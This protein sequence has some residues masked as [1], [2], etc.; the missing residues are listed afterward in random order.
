[1]KSGQRFAAVALLFLAGV[2]GVCEAAL[3]QTV[4]WSATLTAESDGDESEGYDPVAGYGS[5][6][7][8]TFTYKGKSF[9]VSS[10]YSSFGLTRMNF[11]GGGS[12]V[13]RDLFGR[14]ANP[15]PV[16]LNIG[17][18]SWM[19]SGSGANFG[20]GL[21]LIFSEVISAGNTYAVSITTAEPGPPQSLTA[22]EVT[23]TG[24]TLNWSGPSSIGGSAITGYKYR[25]KASGAASFG[26]WTAISNSASL[27]SHPV[28]GLES[29]TQ[30][31]FQI[32]ATNDSGDGLYSGE[33]TATT[34]R[35]TPTVILVLDRDRIS[36]DGGRSTVTA[37]LD[38]PSAAQITVTVSASA[39]LPATAD[40]FTL[41]TNKV[42]TIAAEQTTSTG[43]VTIAAVNNDDDD[44]NRRVTLSGVA[45]SSSTVTQPSSQPLTIVDDESASTKVTLTVS[46]TRVQEDATGA[47]QT[48]TVSAELDGDARTE[49]TQVAVSVSGGSAVAGTHYTAVPGFTFTIAAGQTSGAGTFTLAPID[50]NLNDPEVTVTV[51]GTTTSGLSVEP[52]SGLAVTIEDDDDPPAVTLVLDPDSIDEDGGESTVTATLDKPSIED[53]VITVSPSPV[54]PAIESDFTLSD[55]T[56]LTIR[57]GDTTSSGSVTITA[58]NNDVG[59]GDQRVTVSGEAASDGDLTPPADVTLTI[60]EDDA[61]ATTV[62]LTVD[63][64]TVAED[65]AG[66][67]RTVTVTAVL[68]GAREEATPVAVSVTGGTA[69]A[70]TDYA[71]VDGFTVTIAERMKSGS[72]T[73]TLAPVDDEVDEPGETVVLN[74][75]T[76]VTDLTVAPA[77][78]VTVTITDNDPRPEVTLVLTPAKIDEDDGESTV[79]ATLDRPSSAVTRIMVSAFPVPPAAANEFTLSSN[80]VLTIAAGQKASTG[81][82]TI[83]ANDNHVHQPLSR[84]LVVEGSAANSQGVKPPGNL[85]LTI[86]EDEVA[87]TKVTLSASPVSVS[88]GGGDQTVTLTATMDEGARVSGTPVRISVTGDTAVA[89]TDYSDVNDF[90]FRIL[91]GRTSGTGTFTLTPVD[92]ETDEPDETVTVTATTPDS[93]GL[94]VEPLSGL[95]VTITDDDADAEPLVLNLNVMA[96]DGTVNRAEKAAGFRISGD[97][98]SE[99]GVSV[100]VAVGAA[101]LP[102]TSADESGTATWSVDVPANAAYITGTSVAVEVNASKTGFTAPAAVERSLTVDLVAPTAPSYTAPASLQVGVAMTA[103]SPSG[104]SGIDEYSAVGLPSGLAIQATTGALS[105]TP[106]TADA[107]PAAATV[108]VSD[109]AGNTATVGITLPLVAKGDQPL[110]GFRYSTET[111]TFGATAPTLTAPSGAVTTLGYTASPNTVCTVHATTGALTIVAVGSCRITATAAGNANYNQATATF[112]VTVEAAGQLVLNL[113]VMAGD[114]TVNRAEKAAGFRIS[115]DTGSEA[116]VSVSVAVGAATLP[117]TSADESGTATW[118]VDVPANAAYIT[119]TSVAVEVNASKTGFTAPAAVERSLTVDLVAPTAPSYTAP[120]SLQ[121]GVAMTAISPSGGSGI[122]E[123]SAVGLPSGLAIQATTGALSGT[124][125]TADAAPAAATVTVSDGAGNTATVGITLPLVAKG[126]QPLSGFRYSAETVT[127]GATAPTLTAPS[128]AVTTLGYTASPNTVCTVHATTGALTIVAVGSCRITATAAGNANYN[129]ATATFTVTVEAA[130]QLV[131]NLNVMAGDGT[132]NRAE[133]AAGFR[134]SGDTGSEAGVSVSVAVGAA[135]LPATSADESGTATWSVDVPANAAY[136]TGTSVAVEVNA[137][138]TGFT[139]PAAVERSL[140]VDLVAPTAPS[141]TAPASLQVGVAMTAISPSGGSGIDEYSAVGLPSGLAIQATTGALSG[142]PD[143]ADAAPAAATVTVSDGAGNT[144]TVGITLPLVAKGDQPLSGFRYSA[145][146]VTFGATAPTLT[147][148]SGAVTTLGYTASPNTVCTVH[149]TTGALTI[150]AVGSCRIT[151]TAAGNANYNQATATFT[152]TVEAAGQ[153]VLNLNVMAGDGTVNRAEKAAGFRISGDT[154]SEAGVSVSVAVGA[155]TLPATSADESGTATWSVDVP[156]NAAYITGTSVAVE[157]NAS[158]TGFTAPAA[159]ERSLTVDLVAPTAPSYTAPASLQVGVAMTA[160]SPSGGSGIDEYSAVGLPSGLAI[161]ATTGALSGTPDTADAAPAAATVTV[162]DGAG[163]TATV[164]I[165]LPLVAKGDQPLSGFRYSA[166]TVTF[167]ATAPTL[168]APSGAVTTLGYTASPNTVCTVHATT[169]ALTIVAVGSCRI[170]ATAAGN[171]NYNQA[172]ATFTVTVEAAGQLVLNLNVMAGDGTVNRAEKAAGFRISG[173]TGSEAGVSVSVAVGAATLP[174]TSADESGTATWSVDVP[175]NAAYITGTSVAVE[176]NASKTGFTAPAAVERSL[177]VDLV[178]PTAPSYTAPASLQ[179]GVAMTAI[180]PSGGSGIDEYSAVGLPSGL[181]IQA[182]TGALSGTPD[183][184]DAAPAAATVT[185]S[186]GAG[187]TATVG[188]TLPLVAKGDQPLSGFRYSA[189][190]VTFGATAPTLTAPSGAVTT[191]GYTA[192]PNTVCTVHATTGALT[193]VAVGS[194]RITA[195]AAGNANYNQATATFTVTVEAAGQ[196]VLNLNVMAGDGTVN[197]A[198]KAAGFRISGDTG[199]EAGVSVSVAVGAATLPATSADES[200]TATWSVDVPA[201][202]AYITGTSV[203]VEVNASKTGFTAPAAVERSLTVDLVAP[204]APSYTAPASLQVGVAMTAISPSGGSGIDEYSAVGLPSGLAIQATTGALSG[205]PDTADA[206][207]AAATVTVSDGAGN[208]ATVGITLPL[209]AKGDQPLSGFRYSAETV[210]FG[211]TAPTLTAPSGAVTTLGYTA[212]PNTVCTVHATTGALTI[213]AVGSCRIT[214]TAAGNANY[215]QA[216]A[217]FT[218]TVEAAGQLVLNLNVMA[219]DGTVNRA[220]K[221]AGFRISGDTGSEAGVSVSVAVGAATLPATSADESGTATWSV[222]VP[223]NAAYITGTSVAVEVNASKTGFTAPAAV[224]RSLTVDLV[225]PTAPSYTAPASLQVGVAMTAISPS[226]GSGIDEYSAVGLPSG[227][228]IQATTGALSGTPDTADAAPAAA[229]VTVSDG[230]GNTATVG[231]TLPLVAK[232]DQPLSGFRYSAETVTFGAT[233]PTLTAPSGAVTTLGYTASPNTV[234]TV[235]ATTGALTIVAVGSCRITA[236]AAGNANYNQATATFTVT[237]EAAGQLVLN[238]NV[239]AGDGTVNRAEKAAGFRISGD[240]GSE[241]GVSVSVAVGAATLPATSADESGTATWSVDVPANAAYITG[242]SVAVEVNASKTGFTAPAA[243]ERSLTVDLVAPTAPSY[244]A[245]ASLQVGVAMTAISPSGGSGIDEYSAVGL[246][247]G[248]AIQATTGAL[249]GTPDTADAA[250]A[251][252]TVTVSDGAGNTA[253]VGI[254]LPLVAKGDQPLSGFR[255]SAETVTFG[256]TAPTLTAPSGAVTTLGYT[257]SPNTVCTVHATTGALTIVAVGSCR[258]TATAAGNANYNQATATF[259]VTVEAA[260]QLVLNLNVMAGDGTVNR[261]EKAA[262]FRISGDTGSEAGVSVSVAVGA[263]TLPA[264]SAD[265][266]GTATWSVDVPANAAYITGTSVAV[267]VNASKTGFTAPAAVERSLTV[268]LVAPTAP[269]YTAPA[270]LQVGVAMTAISPSGGSGIDEYSAV[271][272]PSGLAIQAT[273]G[274]LSGTPDTADAAPAAATVTVSDGAGNTATVGI[275]LPLVA[276]G[277]QPLSGFRYSAETV[278]FGA[279]APTLTAPSGAVTTLGY[280]ASP[281]TV[282]TVHATTG[283]LTIVAVGSCRITATAAGNA[284]YNQ[285]TATFTVTVE[286]AGQLVLNLN[287][288]AGDGTVNRAEKAAGFR[289]SGDTG[290]EAGVS[291]SVAVGAAT[292]PATSADESGTA[293]WSVDVPANAAYITGTSVA[294]EVNASKTGFTAP[295]AVERS[296]TVDLVAPTAPSY[297]AP[298]SLQVGVAMTAISPSGGSGIDEYSAVGLPSGLAIQA[299]TGALSGTPDTADA[300]PAAATVTVSDGAGNTATVGI[301]LPLVAK[302]DQPLSGFRYSAETVTFGATAPTLTAPSGAVTT[303]GY[304][305]SPNTVCTVHATTGALTIVAVGSCRITATAAG[306]ANYNQ[307]TATFTVTVE[308]AGQL[309]LNL[310]VMAGDGTVNRAEKAAGFRISGDTGS[311]AGVSVSVA[312]GAATLPATSADESGTATWSVDVPANAA[313]ITGTSVAVEVNASKTGF[314]A[315]AAVERSLTVDL[316]APTAPSYTAPASLQVGVAM[317]AISPSGGSGIDEYSAVGLPSGLAIQA[318]TGALSGT[319]DTADAAPAAATVTVSDGAGNTATVGITLPL[320]AKGD[321]PLSG[322]RYSAETVTF[323]ATAPTLTAPS[324]AVTTLGYTASPNTV[325]TVHATTGALTIVAVGS[326]RITATAAGNANYNQA[327]ATFTV[328]VESAGTLITLTV[329]DERIDEDMG[330]T[331][332]TVTGTL[333]N[334][335][336]DTDTAVTVAVGALSDA[337]AEGTDYATVNDVM[338]TISAGQSSGAATLSLRLTDDDVD[339]VDETLSLTGSTSVSGLTVTGTTITIADNDERGVVV[340]PTSL[341]VSEGHSSTYSV[342]LTSEPTGPVKVTPSVIGSSNVTLNASSFTFT[343]SNWDTVQTVTVLGIQDADAANETATIGHTLI[344]ADYGANSVTVDDVSVIVSDDETASTGIALTVSHEGIDED[345][346]ATTVTVTGTLNHAPRTSA[347]ALAVSVGAAGDTAVE[348]TDYGT[349]NDLRLTIRTGATT[350]TARFTLT[351][352]DDDVDEADEV[353]TVGGSTAVS[354]LT[355]SG[356]TITIA[357][358]DERAVVVTPTLL[359]VSEG[360]SLTYSVVLT[361]EPA[362]PVTVTPSVN[363]SAGVTLDVSSLKFT[364]SNWDSVQTVTVSAAQDTDEV[365]DTAT[366]EHTVSGADYGANSVTADDVAVTV[367]DDEPAS[368]GITLTVTPKQLDEDAGR[369]RVTVTGTLNHAP[370]TSSTTVTV[371]VGASSDAAAEGIDYAVVNDLTL[372]IDAGATTGTATFTLTP[373][374]DKVDEGDETLEVA[375]ASTAAGLT[376]TGTTVTIKENDESGLEI[377]TALLTVPEGG[378]STYMVALT[379]E[380]TDK[381]TVTMSV[382]GD[383][384]LTLNPASLSFTAQDWATAQIV[385]VSAAGDA[386]IADDHASILHA[387]AGGDYVSVTADDVSVTVIDDFMNNNVPVFPAELPSTL[388]VAE[389]AAADTA[390]GAP[391]PATDFDGHTLAYALEGLDADSFAI[392][393]ASA[394]LKALVALDHEIR[395]SYS[396]RV[397]ANDGHGG[398]AGIPV[399]VRVTDVT[400]QPGTPASPLVLASA[401]ST[402][403]LR[404]RWSAPDANGGPAITGYAVQYRVATTGAWTFHR[405][406]GTDTRATIT[407][408][409]A[410]TDYQARVRALNGEIPGE[411]SQPGSGNTGKAANEAPVFDSGLPAVLT[412]DENNPADIELGGPFTATDTDGDPLTYLLDGAGRN[413]FA[414][415]P[416]SGQIRTRAA[417]DHESKASYSV[418]VRADD[419]NGGTGSIALTVSVTDVDEQVGTPGAPLVLARRGSSISVEVNWT[420]PNTNGGPAIAGYAV[421]YREVDEVDLADDGAWIDHGHR[422]TGTRAVISS[423]NAATSYQARVRALNGETPGEWSEPGAGSTGTPANRPP[424][425]DDGLPA[426]VTVNENIV[427]NVDIGTPFAASDA[428]GDTLTFLMDGAGRRA[429]AI[430]PD[431][432]QLRT[433]AALDHEAKST[434]SLRVRVN[435]GKGGADAVRV[436]VRIIDLD[437]QA[438]PLSAPGVLASADSITS[439]DLYWK[440]PARTGGPAIVGY[441]VQYRAGTEGDW[442]DHAHEGAE[443]RAAVADLV[444]AT[445]YQARVRALNGEIPGEWSEPGAGSTGHAMNNAPIFAPGLPATLMVGENTAADSDIGAP[446]AATDS[447]GDT[448]TYLLDGADRRAFTIDPD[449]GQLRTSAALDHETKS[450]YVL[451][452]RVSDGA[453]GADTAAVTVNV[454]DRLEKAAQTSPPFVLSAVGA[455]MALDVRWTAPSANGG[456]AIVGYEMQYREGTDDPW[457]DHAHE[458]A[459]TRA[460]IAD[461]AATTGYQVRVRALNGETPGDWSAPGSGNTA[462]PE[463]SAPEFAGETATR[464]VPENSEAGEA[465]GAAVTAADADRDSLT[466]FLEG[467]DAHAFDIDAQTGQ[468]LTQAPLDYETQASYSVMVAANDGSGAADTIDVTIELMDMQEQQAALGPAAPTRVS[469]ARQ[470]SL[471]SGN[472]VQSQITL[473]WDAKGSDAISWFEFR[474]GR[475]PEASGGLAPPEFQCA[476]NRPFEPDGWRRIPDSG[477]EGANARSY[478]FDAQTLGCH[479]LLDTYELRAQARAVSVG[480]EGTSVTVS[481]ASTEARMRDEAPRVVGTWLDSAVASLPETGEDL[482]LVVAFTEPV[483]VVMANGSPTLEIGLGD[484]TR[485]A[486]FAAAARPPAFRDYGSGHIGSRLEFRYQV[487]EDDDLTAGIVVPANAISISSGARI[488][489]ATG[490]RGHAADLRNPRTTISEGSTVV[491]TSRQASLTASFEPDSVPGEHDG[492]TA[493]SVQVRFDASA[494]TDAGAGGDASQQTG[495]ADQGDQAT[496]ETPAELPEVTLAESSFLVTGGRIASL[497]RLAE[498]DNQRWRVGVEPDSNA[499]VTISLGP[500]F[501]CADEG[502]VC[503]EDGRILA[504]NIHAVIKGPPGFS[505]TDARATEAPD[506]TMDFVVTLSRALPEAVSVD[507]ATSDGT[508]VAGEDYTAISGTLAFEAGE[509]SKTVPVPVLDDAHDDH[510]ETFTLTLSNPSGSNA[511]LV[512]DTATGTIE[513]S[514]PMPKA[515]I[516]RFGRAVSDHVVDAI[517]ARFSDGPREAHLTLGGLRMDGLFARSY[518][519]VSQQPARPDL[520]TGGLAGGN[521]VDG[522][523]ASHGQWGGGGALPTATYPGGGHTGGGF[524]SSNRP[525]AASDRAE[526]YVN[527]RPSLKDILMGSS[528]F[529]STAQGELSSDAPDAGGIK[530]WSAWGHMAATRFRGEDGPL[531]LDGEV[532][533][534]VLGVDAAWN[535]WLAG[536]VL[537]RSEGEGGYAHAAASGGSV[538]SAL[539][540]LHP[541][542]QYRV[543]ERT[544]VWGTIGYGVGDLSL[545]PKAS[546]ASVD[547]DLRMAMGAV[548]GRGLLSMRTGA[549]GSFELAVRSDALLTRTESGA[550]ENLLSASGATSR[551]RVILE[552]RGS[553]PLAIGGVLTPTLEAGLRYDGGDAETGAGLE[554]GAGLGY[555]NHRLQVQVNARV[556]MAHEDDEYEEWG[557]SGSLAYRPRNDG[558]GLSLRLGSAWGATQSGVQALWSRQDAR[559]LARGGAAMAGAQRIQAQLGYGVHTSNGHALWVPYLAADAARHGSR[560]LRLGVKFTADSTIQA[561]LELGRRAGGREAPEYGLQIHGS[562]RW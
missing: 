5:L 67:D 243:V 112:T 160:I 253:T 43:T 53:I 556:L 332:M 131:L 437:E 470:L 81:T 262:G 236:T 373:A 241:A 516:A 555:G 562:A 22:T 31:T 282:C 484:E 221:A 355:V 544:S 87:S 518:S 117:A 270:S 517:Q 97:T 442:I 493:F 382:R 451:S 162:S 363:G 38:Q 561:G 180:S 536:V 390:I 16:T 540:S 227:L 371:S 524:P 125:D 338:L 498:D 266:S 1:M 500:S 406:T 121:V 139:A 34:L 408:L 413:A 245:P 396:L 526:G 255:Y 4:I 144:A 473:R 438:P 553:L 169:G 551:V 85:L 416:D 54:P 100:S 321:Q 407:G 129:Q 454:A 14:S 384:D 215:N 529:Y 294:V 143:T 179:V 439:L 443:T 537:A 326:C 394:Q 429:F 50:D 392:D 138:K 414:I 483:R 3:A 441:A 198:E 250:P 248:L 539:T 153:L 166:E 543:N 28:Q 21:V 316:V 364:A 83:A 114:G 235:H 223:A 359:I 242:T 446:F 447:D 206:A 178:A 291:V 485:R 190:T 385:T 440:A 541:F 463:N 120:A 329:S 340:T 504:N 246:P 152:V 311:E 381:V 199:S 45:A 370:R 453:G 93:V 108:T 205:T 487:Q 264:T 150:V 260:G 154:G 287:V 86:V 378:S 75:T 535:R 105:G 314:T 151:A 420:A 425:F 397:T 482:V 480:S 346:G 147:A 62:T 328:T 409:T 193:I 123:Y 525:Q 533:T 222:D 521:L 349:L 335:P 182:T 64:S 331:T 327:T 238:L 164:G 466:Y 119:G 376:V 278:T 297:T 59:A 96:G 298:A 317:T 401:G 557:L 254:T 547:T 458:G 386:D 102:A 80:K 339:E 98:G 228:A 452:V 157:V 13:E 292:L 183:T 549:S 320:V 402:T 25:Y 192:S 369:T 171:A 267:E 400:E 174:A 512:H 531:S 240:T 552:G 475:Y 167:G 508:A 367:G 216:T 323:G 405:H 58:N 319:P 290:S 17:D 558:A 188:I 194:C 204:T 419:R 69:V 61:V 231:I 494:S 445:E 472:V 324:G 354:D 460:S 165:T 513:N 219:G 546:S 426:R 520:L 436:R 20:G 212:S 161:Q 48:V 379:S 501:D 465:V 375:G 195:T 489:D 393:A 76:T 410:A 224:E 548:G 459:E 325:C 44:D 275:T 423:L 185:V 237:V 497:S 431:S 505:V 261:A 272:L 301:T 35:G 273:T 303:L 421:Q 19:A 305:A 8:S 398:R 286:A 368:T 244:T 133:K 403:S 130:G 234:C 135:T 342:V 357:D 74:G 233:A 309:V 42:L 60:T 78:G 239:M 49:A 232:G 283:A 247:S 523:L 534:G 280:T 217:T 158:K 434:Y 218:V 126:D 265:E 449:S 40:D 51:T 477:P 358:D 95:T 387:L 184:A 211:A 545:T 299:T 377:S 288:M 351:S 422:G 252:A 200:G 197:R 159:V 318:T 496:S 506:A 110:S 259:T 306:N 515:W 71:A 101:T 450:S 134:I 104:G 257:A 337:A 177:T 343:K 514:D 415:D 181:A 427:A 300:A 91:P 202:A 522:A 109:G 149:A 33:V 18:G 511:Y 476:G 94:P 208:T 467:A 146:T 9:T 277:D 560:A 73:F 448:L 26:D 99:A 213:V 550:S 474:I 55:E 37:I 115:G 336:R 361:S 456:P 82:V 404:L 249:S 341:M 457:I 304:T 352:R 89:G 12:H 163:N 207:P 172:T 492:E 6:S 527:V 554:I 330:A 302:G 360:R 77:D 499:E 276:K 191:L 168:T 530:G 344:G 88:E 176:V 345:A 353:L 148:P 507:Y 411:W 256:A 362:G 538:T 462:R 47:A 107:A 84:H 196:L 116:G 132:V 313:Y 124:P 347:T 424:V 201:N 509:T 92:D 136:I 137:S 461:L 417:L 142:T 366:I 103:I 175:A 274:A 111:V 503:T 46:P 412:V 395:T 186:D 155:A 63:A 118:S 418:T 488:V 334:A 284:N 230:A 307:A 468:I 214:A 281:N 308:A 41:S 296:L 225:A 293:T 127:F 469:L 52:E 210:T 310:N 56:A 57:A 315:P 72:A 495:R 356:T 251:A 479:V 433:R 145:E 289:I 30:Y 491:A 279:T 444:A 464:S 122:D 333:D 510:G 90:T 490:P 189:E 559:G 432:G 173:D 268:D 70:G 502:A 203:A 68:D 542:A 15:R 27:T 519:G 532:A 29:A 435:D 348:G 486:R 430:D 2:L 229:T 141:Y 7:S 32:L 258:I 428:D 209:V 471:N 269:S 10:I 23:S 187:N 36:E 113:N 399:T 170:T 156:A 372:A 380:P 389:N 322:F 271:G 220:E 79:T 106:D 295:A 226:G 285:A 365:N 24:V 455:T 39:V 478:R 263:A 391:L 383:S 128:G 66:S 388:E 350:G 140:T 374:D 528:F 11:A 65:A 312:V 481:A